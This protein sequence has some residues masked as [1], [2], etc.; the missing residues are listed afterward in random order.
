MSQ[1]KETICDEQIQNIIHHWYMVKDISLQG[2]KGG[3]GPEG[4]G[5][6][7]LMEKR[8]GFTKSYVEFA[9]G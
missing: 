1:S 3:E 5:L 8:H 7:M 2:K 4:E 9:F 6:I